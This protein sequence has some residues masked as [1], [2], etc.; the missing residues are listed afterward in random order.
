M[1][2]ILAKPTRIPHD[3]ARNAA[4]RCAHPN[5]TETQRQMWLQARRSEFA[6]LRPGLKGEAFHLQFTH[7]LESRA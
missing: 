2:P 4:F 3:V 5:G 1:T 7:W 6:R